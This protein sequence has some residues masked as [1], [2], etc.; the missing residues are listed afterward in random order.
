MNRALILSYCSSFTSFLIRLKAEKISRIILFGSVAR[1]QFDK[2]SDIDIFIDTK[3]DP[4]S[5]RKILKLYEQSE[6]SKKFKLLGVDLPLSIHIGDLN[7]RTDLKRSMLGNAIVLYS[8]F[9]ES[10]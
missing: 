10:P 7:K 3:E 1:N 2:E 5:I 6:D 8:E 9:H 4:E